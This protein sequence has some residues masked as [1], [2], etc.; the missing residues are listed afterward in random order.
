MSWNII[1]GL[2]KLGTTRIAEAMLSMRASCSLS[3]QADI[4]LNATERQNLGALRPL[5]VPISLRSNRE[6]DREGRRLEEEKEDSGVGEA[7]GSKEERR[8]W[9]I[10]RGGRR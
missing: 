7:K 2:G 5:S 10:Y 9:G 3:L 6:K 8:G 4:V 1:P